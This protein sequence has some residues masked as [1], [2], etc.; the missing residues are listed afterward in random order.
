[1]NLILRY[2]STFVCSTKIYR[3][4]EMYSHMSLPASVDKGLQKMRK[5]TLDSYKTAVIL[6][7]GPSIMQLVHTDFMKTYFL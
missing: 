5:M 6:I 2:V 4:H 7:F 3:S 1:M